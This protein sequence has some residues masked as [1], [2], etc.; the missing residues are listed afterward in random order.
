[1]I[2]QESERKREEEMKKYAK[3]ESK[4]NFLGCPL[5]SRHCES[6]GKL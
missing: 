3:K 6:P 5:C 2:T 4:E 1:M